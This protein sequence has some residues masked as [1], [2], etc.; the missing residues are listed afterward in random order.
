MKIISERKTE[1][2]IRRPNGIVETMVHPKIDWFN[3]VIFSQMKKAMN[4]AGRGEVLGYRNIEAVIEMEESDYQQKCERCGNKIDTRKSYSQKEWSRF[5]TQ[6]VQVTAFYC[7]SCKNILN[8]IGAGE[9]TDMEHRAGYV[10]SYEPQTK[11]D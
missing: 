3:D 9:I 8:T 4:D 11:E 7:N 6:K 1:V 10:P 5:G 2:T